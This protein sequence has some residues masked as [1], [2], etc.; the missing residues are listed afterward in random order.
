MMRVLN[1][2][3]LTVLATLVV[4]ADVRAQRSLSLADAQAEARAN[5]PEIG[6]L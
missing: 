5:A 6:E 1:L 4:A 2:L 3:L